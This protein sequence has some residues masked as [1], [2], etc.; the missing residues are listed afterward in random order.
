M[1]KS[2]TPN[3]ITDIPLTTSSKDEKV[4]LKKL[5]ASRQLYNACLGEAM[6]RVRLVQQSKLYQYAQ[7][8][9][10]IIKNKPNPERKKAFKKAWES[11]SFSDYYLQGYSTKIR[12][13]WIKDHIDADTAQKL[14]TRAFKAARNVL[15]GRAKRVRFKG[16]NQMDSLEGKSQRSPL[17]WDAE[18][19][20]VRWG[21]KGLSLS[22]VIDENDPVIL[23][24]INSP[25]KY[26]RLVRRK[27]ND[28]NRFYAQLI[29]EGKPFQKPKN[30]IGKGLVGLDVGPSTL[31]M[32]NNNSAELTA[33][34]SELNDRSQ[35]IKR[36][37]KQMSRSIRASNPD[38][39]EPSKC[40]LPKP[41]QKHGK[42][43]LGKS[44][45]GKRQSVRSNRYQR[46]RRQKAELERKLA[47]HRK[48]LQGELA[49]KVV[50]MG[51]YINT[52]KL[53]YKAWQK[54][55]GRSVGR[56]APG[57]FISSLK[58][59][60]E[61]AGGWV[62]EFSTKNTK[63]SQRCICGSFQKK[64]LKQR[65]H[66]CS[67]GVYAQRDLFS[68]YLARFVDLNGE[69]QAIPALQQYQGSDP[70]L[71]AAW[72]DACNKHK[73]S[74]IG[75][76]RADKVNDLASE[77]IAQKCS[78]LSSKTLD[79]VGHSRELERAAKSNRTPCL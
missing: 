42:R 13:S 77:R 24:G 22:P 65:E 10:R 44:V 55:F 41:G 70:I 46:L 51:K 11:Y 59:I 61:N 73:Q 3:F 63:L 52:E 12:D 35:Q 54:L 20:I 76:P 37:Q 68:G 4:L 64:P 8:L 72:N 19:Q 66:S 48:S 45:K 28:K 14:A 78:N 56:N 60:A 21:K 34:C 16:V 29:N 79:V 74:S 7:S 53:S 2:N 26:V 6:K 43:K 15:I 5:E 58:Q 49:H 33:F 1:P 30:V 75:R 57:G 23:H 50:A 18:N 17:K 27:I 25:V 67:C 71:L 9:P 47:A 62:N 40:D 31:A 36:I 38:C 32:V 69:F 39:F